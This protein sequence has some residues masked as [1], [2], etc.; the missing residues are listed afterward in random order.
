MYQHDKK[1]GDMKPYADNQMTLEDVD[2]DV[3]PCRKDDPSRSCGSGGE[4][5]RDVN[6]LYFFVF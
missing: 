5:G 1:L 4:V 2:H 3:Y 6:V